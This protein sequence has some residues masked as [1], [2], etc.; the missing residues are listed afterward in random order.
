MFLVPEAF[1]KFYHDRA[2][3]RSDDWFLMGSPWPVLCIAAS[4]VYFVT[5]L[6]PRFMKNR[7]AFHVDPIVRV[8]N[9]LQIFLCLC[10]FIVGLNV[11]CGR[12]FR[13]ICQPVDYSNT[14]HAI[15][16]ARLAWLY[17]LLKVLD[18]CDTVFFILRKKSGQV[19]FLHMYHHLMMLLTVW[20]VNKFCPGNKMT[21]DS[22]RHVKKISFLGIYTLLLV[23]I[24]IEF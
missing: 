1:A 7:S 11:V 19:S 20:T 9:L 16:M 15:R 6:G 2:D 12:T 17:F 8:Y 3:H 22:C 10:L 5:N 23:N 14:P 13:F 4:Y 21:G 18:L 24:I